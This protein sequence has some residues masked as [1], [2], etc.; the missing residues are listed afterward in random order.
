MHV[1]STSRPW[2]HLKTLLKAL[3]QAT[4]PLP[5]LKAAVAEL[6]GCIESYEAMLGERKE[7]EILYHELEELFQALQRNC[8]QSVPPAVT[9][10]IEALCG[11]IQD[12]IASLREIQSKGKLREYL[13]AEQNTDAVLA[14]YRRIQGYLRRVSDS[15]LKS[16]SPSLS[17]CYNSAQAVDLKRGP[18]TKGTRVDLLNQMLDWVDSSS[19]G[20]VYWMSGMAGTG[21]T[22]ITYSLCEV[23]DANH[24][25][26]AS[27]FGSRLLPECRDV[28]LIIPSIA[29]QLARSSQPFQCVLL[30]VLEKDPDVHTRLPHLQ[31]DTL[32][33]KPLLE[34]KDMLP[35]NLVVVID[36]LD[37]CENK[38][39]TSR[40]LDVLLTKS[41]HLPVKFIM[42]SRPEPEIRDEMVKQNDQAKSRVVLH[43]LDKDTVQADIETYLRFALAQ[44]QPTEDEITTLVERAGILFIY[45]ATVVRYIS[46]YRFRRNP[47]AR[48]ANVLESSSA[49]ENKHR[50]IDELY[51]II[52][53]AALDDPTLD[54]SEREDVH[55]VLHSVI[56]TR[57]PLTVDVLSKLLGMND[58]D[59]VRAALRPLWSVLNISGTNELVTTL[60]ASFPDYMLDPSHSKQYY[61]DSRVHNQTIAQRCFDLF[62][63]TR[64]QFNICNLES[65]YISDD[66]V[67]GLEERINDAISTELFYASRYWAI[68]LHSATGSSD[69]TLE[70]E[71]FLSARLLLWMEVMSLKQ[72]TG[73]MPQA[74]RLVETWEV[75]RSR[76]LNALI[77]DA[78]RFTLAFAFGAI[79]N[80]TPHLYMSML[81]SWPDS[82]PVA[83]CYARYTWRVI[84]AEGSAIGQRQHA[85]LATWT[86]DDTTYT[87]AFSPDGTQ[88]AVGVGAEV[89]L[90]SSSTGRMLLPPFSGHTAVISCVQFS[91][92]GTRIVSTT[93]NLYDGAIR[94]WSTKNGELVL[95]LEPS[96]GHP[97]LSASVAFSHDGTRIA[98]GSV[99]GKIRIWDARNGE[100]VLDLTTGDNKEVKLIKYSSDG[101]FILTC[102]E[103][104][105]VLIWDAQEGRM[106]RAIGSD[107][108]LHKFNSADFSP[109][110]TRVATALYHS[111]IYIW[112][113]YG[114]RLGLGP[115]MAPG[116]D[117]SINLVSFSPNGF[118]IISGSRRGTVCIWDTRSGD[119]LF[120]PLREHTNYLT[121]ICFSPDSAYFTSVSDNKTLCLWDTQSMKSTASPLDG[122]ADSVRSVGFSPDGTRVIS[123]S[124]D[125]TL[126]IWDAES[127]EMI[128][129]RGKCH[130]SSFPP[131]F[132]PD[133]ARII[134]GTGHGAMVLDAHTGDVAL[135]TLQCHKPI[136]SVGLSPDSGCIAIGSRDG[137]V[138]ILALDTGQ[139]CKKCGG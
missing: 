119:L 101:R 105:N 45:A 100:N 56:C 2:G 82:S 15:R 54:N 8:T 52:L 27:F 23:L 9:E 73:A 62:R 125:D 37:E 18:C 41:S 49:S 126:C 89:L 137:V 93:G 78:W 30:K 74:I 109:D 135:G 83:E 29:Y 123:S 16:L 22:T 35:D 94:V 36:A 132:F 124:G 120:G 95:V 6:S 12:E 108:G 103:R 68:H 67:E 25:L 75:E 72:C 88:I 116:D 79:S 13:K 128:L 40:I 69:L 4:R 115:L 38:E 66:Q 139:L 50:E 71:K 5:P 44:V 118:H 96:E 81:P 90:L 112:E 80:S 51:A 59:R 70:L 32:I 121:S 111:S 98:S 10:V 117:N 20:S 138:R 19:L 129:E 63:D 58:A 7:Y 91:P 136:D 24:K 57:E 97:D 84:Q 1:S 110:G 86:F 85:L 77:H 53:R 3:E 47:R 28:N 60:H 92:D 11:S 26:A 17:A 76:E 43:E 134:S 113:D 107:N 33:S 104:W 127:G 130:D 102:A 48:L 61:C 133:G 87:S 34:V 46:H 106:L 114:T 42:S 39:S 31:F 21:K 99:D 14:S 122:H 55:Q 65:S 64:P 131:E